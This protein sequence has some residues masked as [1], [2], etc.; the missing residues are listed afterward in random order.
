MPS[1]PWPQPLPPTSA[2]VYG[3]IAA[4][5]AAVPAAPNSGPASTPVLYGTTGSAAA[6]A[7]ASPAGAPV[8]A[9]ANQL[10]GPAVAATSFAGAAAAPAAPGTSGSLSRQRSTLLGPALEESTTTGLSLPQPPMPHSASFHS[11]GA[12]SAGP[13]PGATELGPELGDERYGQVLFKTR[14]CTYN[15]MGCC[16]RRICRFAHSEE[17]LRRNPDWTKTVLC[18]F[19]R[20]RGVCR[21]PGCTYAHSEAELRAAGLARSRLGADL[22]APAPFE[23]SAE[24]L[25][26]G[27]QANA[28]VQAGITSRDLFV[29]RSSGHSTDESPWPSEHSACVVAAAAAAP[30]ACA[31]ASW[32]SASGCTTSAGAAATWASSSAGSTSGPLRIRSAHPAAFATWS[33]APPPPLWSSSDRVVAAAPTWA[34]APPSVSSSRPA[35]LIYSAPLS[36]PSAC[37]AAAATSTWV[38]EPPSVPPACPPSFLA[39]AW[40]AG[41]TTHLASLSTT[42]VATMSRV[43]AG[44]FESGEEFLRAGELQESLA[45]WGLPPPALERSRSSSAGSEDS[46]WETVRGCDA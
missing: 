45:Q 34:S 9:G 39:S 35:E 43:D 18:K 10:I 32:A 28:Q 27:G 6:A 33:S 37:A 21:R 29:S 20:D 25:L 26:L 2:P 46:M 36:V 41:G 42:R 15:M 12:S 22:L 17:E 1:A 4:A 38:S 23:A 11:S 13:V 24:G 5:E 44:F 40:D 19:V 3:S 16:R 30:P 31:A 7:E 8:V 14:L